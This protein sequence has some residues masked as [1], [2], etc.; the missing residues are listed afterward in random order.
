M[1]RR[2]LIL[3][4]AVVVL[5]TLLLACDFGGDEEARLQWQREVLSRQRGEAPLTPSPTQEAK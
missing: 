4:L 1:N 5:G 3:I 2:T